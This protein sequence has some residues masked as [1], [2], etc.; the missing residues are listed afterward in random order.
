[1][2]FLIKNKKSEH[3]H[4]IL[5]IRISPGAIFLGAIHFLANQERVDCL[6]HLY[7]HGFNKNAMALLGPS[8]DSWPSMAPLGHVVSTKMGKRLARKQKPKRK[9]RTNW[10]QK[11]K[12]IFIFFFVFAFV[13]FYFRFCFVFQ[14]CFCF[15]F[16][17]CFC[18]HFS[19]CFC[20]YFSFIF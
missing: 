5:H 12:F 13:F 14:F 19:F 7:A 4:W 6:W 8:R 10:K 17:F 11:Q 3:R 15:H 9:W 16:R 20:F 1:M 2:P 18:F